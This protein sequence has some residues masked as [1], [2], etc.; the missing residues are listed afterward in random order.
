[1]LTDLVRFILVISLSFIFPQYLFAE[2]H[3]L[4][5]LQSLVLK[6]NPRIKAMESEV[7]MLKKRIAVSSSLEDPKVKIGLNNIPV[8][9]FS[10]RKEDMTSKE[11]GISQM[12]P[13]GGKRGIKEE[14]A[15]KEYYKALQ[16]LRKERIETLNM[17]RMNF[18]ELNYIRSSQKIVEEIRE[19]LNLVVDIETSGNKSGMGS[20]A[21]VIKANIERSMLEEEIIN[22]TQKEKEV[23]KNISY[24]AGR[25]LSVNFS[26]ISTFRFENLN[27]NEILDR[28]FIENP[29]IKILKL[30]KEIS[31]LE[32]SLREREYYPDLE[33]GISYMQR[34]DSPYGMKRADMISAMAV[35][36]IPLWYKSKNMP[37]IAE[38]QRKRSFTD[39]LIED[40][41][42]ELSAKL[43][44]N[45]SLLKKWEKLYLLY[46][47]DLIPQNELLLDTLIS[48]YRTGLG[49]FMQVIDTLR[50]LLKYKRETEM[51][52]KEYLSTISQINSLSGV[53]ILR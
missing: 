17:F 7:E 21:N 33:L 47:K 26:N 48:R 49:D 8:N 20:L 18:Y 3:Y 46:K 23:L 31:E 4:V 32:T 16:R 28:V 36:N 25:D 22:L 5:E 51:M 6:E 2:N 30:D 1:M 53:E 14:I 15:I 37:M 34:D 50:T 29:D 13:L 45:I 42:N 40:K 39:K 38:M 11:I 27:L 12:I 24:L 44:T 35:F 41:K 10:L 9:D 52:K 43:E 19:Y